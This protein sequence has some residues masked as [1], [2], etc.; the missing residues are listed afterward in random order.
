MCKS[1]YWPLTGQG[2][3]EYH[4][5]DGPLS[6]KPCN[7]LPRTHE[8]VYLVI[9]RRLGPPLSHSSLGYPGE[10]RRRTPYSKTAQLSTGISRELHVLE[11]EVALDNCDVTL[12][13]Q[14]GTVLC[15]GNVLVQAASTK[16]VQVNGRLTQPVKNAKVCEAYEMQAEKGGEYGVLQPV[17][18]Q[19]DIIYNDWCYESATKP[20]CSYVSPWA[21][22]SVLRSTAEG[23]SHTID[24]NSWGENLI[25]LIDKAF[26]HKNKVDTVSAGPARGAAEQPVPEGAVAAAGVNPGEQDEPNKGTAETLSVTH[27]TEVGMECQRDVTGNVLEQFTDAEPEKLGMSPAIGSA[28]VEHQAVFTSS[29]EKVPL[30]FAT[31]QVSASESLC[32]PSVMKIP[33]KDLGLESRAWFIT[34][35]LKEM[36]ELW[37]VQ[38]IYTSVS[39]PQSDCLVLRSTTRWNTVGQAVQSK[40]KRDRNGLFLSLLLL[41]K[42]AATYAAGLRA[43]EIFETDFGEVENKP[44][45]SVVTPPN[46]Q[47]GSISAAMVQ[48]GAGQLVKGVYTAPVEKP[49]E[50]EEP[51]VDLKA[52]EILTRAQTKVVKETGV[53]SPVLGLGDKPNKVPGTGEWARSVVKIVCGSDESWPVPV[54][55][56]TDGIRTGQVVGQLPAEWV[57]PGE[58]ASCEVPVGDGGPLVCV[59]S[60]DSALANFEKKGIGDMC[61]I[62]RSNVGLNMSVNDEPNNVLMVHDNVVPKGTGKPGN[63]LVTAESGTRNK[64]WVS[65]L[66]TIEIG[67]LQSQNSTA[68]KVL[69]KPGNLKRGGRRVGRK[70]NRNP[71]RF[72]ER[73]CL[74]KCTRKK[75]WEGCINAHSRVT[76]RLRGRHQRRHWVEF[77]VRRS[78]V[79]QECTSVNGIWHRGAKSNL[80][81]PPSGSK[82]RGGMFLEAHPEKG[83]A[84]VA[85]SQHRGVPTIMMGAGVPPSGLK[86]RGGDM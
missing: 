67:P 47:M 49:H 5:K 27:K 68:E 77:P 59:P 76:V 57:N 52:A 44:K 63:Q 86:Q 19:S 11:S 72:Q 33:R 23:S 58:V 20:V 7:Q 69:W 4:I 29:C 34:E 56:N 13:G 37:D 65:V 40:A 39:P 78:E 18:P 70:T 60:A 81:V 32:I 62:E 24:W 45:M 55:K 54:D 10:S 35:A 73:K 1:P 17:L 51:C 64:R 74:W 15:N 61:N 42:V 28:L 22:G 43:E 12:V 36:L 3:V 50:V 16:N 85:D 83:W 75:S 25:S 21:E 6:I 48:C 79:G 31:F 80:G 26:M 53:P 66:N 41:L 82:Q 71:L 14:N 9:R 30:T 8:Y 38:P 2:F 46:S 84:Y